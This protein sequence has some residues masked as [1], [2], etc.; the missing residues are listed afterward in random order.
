ME[1]MPL[2][3]RQNGQLDKQDPDR[4]VNKTCSLYQSN[5]SA[6]CLKFKLLNIMII[7]AVL[8]FI[9]PW[10]LFQFLNPTSSL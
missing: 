5:S 1:V 7:T 10:Q 8:P 3:N 2:T 4:S 9:G 6:E